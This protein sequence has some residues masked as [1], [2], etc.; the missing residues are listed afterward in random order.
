[1][2]YWTNYTNEISEAIELNNNIYLKKYQFY[3]NSRETK[4]ST[5]GS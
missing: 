2:Q 5:K 3:F 1:M 4:H